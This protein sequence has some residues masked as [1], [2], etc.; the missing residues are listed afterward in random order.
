MTL[1]SQTEPV[2]GRRRS[3]RLS[4][5]I[6]LQHEEERKDTF[7][8]QPQ[9]RKLDN[10]FD[11]FVSTPNATPT[12]KKSLLIHNCDLK[13]PGFETPNSD[14]GSSYGSPAS[15][16]RTPVSQNS[17]SQK[18]LNKYEGLSISTKGILTPDVSPNKRKCSHGNSITSP[19]RTDGN[20][21]SPKKKLSFDRPE[22]PLTPSS[23]R[24][25]PDFSTSSTKSL[26]NIY[27]VIKRSLKDSNDESYDGLV[28]P[29]GAFLET[30]ENEYKSIMSFLS[31]TLQSNSSSSLYITGP[32]GT[33]KTAQ[34]HKIVSNHVKEIA[35]ESKG[36]LA[37]TRKHFTDIDLKQHACQVCILNCMSLKTPK[38]IYSHLYQ[39]FA[40]VNSKSE[41]SLDQ[42]QEFLESRR[43][44]SF[45][46]VLD[47]I[48]HLCNGSVLSKPILNDLFLATKSDKYQ[49]VLIG[50]SNSLDI[51][52]KFLSRLKLDVNLQPESI[53]FKPYTQDQIFQILSAKLKSIPNAAQ[54]VQ[55]LALRFLSKKMSSATGDLRKVLDV[56]TRSIEMLELEEMRANLK[57]GPADPFAADD[58]E[59]KPVALR[60][61][62]VVHISRACNYE[63]DSS[64]TKSRIEKLNLQQK[65]ILVCLIHKHEHDTL[66]N[67]TVD[68][69]YDYYC[70]RLT[71]DVPDLF[72]P[73]RRSEYGEISNTLE[74]M[75]L[76]TITIGKG[77][78]RKGLSPN[79]KGTGSPSKIKYSTK[80]LTSQIKLEQLK[81][82]LGELGILEKFL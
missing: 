36:K 47:E 1:D 9:Q 33:G 76:C 79:K 65:I 17:K 64:N 39:S 74:M 59:S 30:R 42:L 55:P 54:V 23:T 37:T 3:S 6:L 73:V 52:D 44:T 69:C 22:T 66:G 50:I 35:T 20:L 68:E 21:E 78:N 19:S 10:K 15:P 80:T 24:N 46:V 63:I 31:R 67:F 40:N 2:S 56:L 48:D 43:A 8:K 34:V 45:I 72:T 4:M 61:V 28:A 38:T 71:L 25:N 12:K 32:P 53:I 51:T 60:K 5:R 58:N 62:T 18:K 49:L 57:K 7:Q 77:M 14:F 41:K 13:F 82:D 16:T 75:G 70:K 29:T 11:D 27:T 26:T 81:K